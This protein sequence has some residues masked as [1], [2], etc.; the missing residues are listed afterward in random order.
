MGGTPR[1]YR[2]KGSFGAFSA[3]HLSSEK[4]GIGDHHVEPHQVVPLDERRAVQGVAPF[5]ARG[6]LLVQEH[7]HPR[8]GPGRAVDLLPVEGVV[9]RTDFVGGADQQRAGPTG[10][11]AYRV[12][13]LGCGEPGEQS[14]NGGRRIEF[15][16]LLAGVRREAR[17]E[18]EITL[19]DD[20]FGNLRRTKVE[21]RVCEI[22]EEVDEAAVAVLHPSEVGF[23]VEVDVAENAFELRT[24]RVLDL[25]Q[26]DVD[27]LAN[28]RF[29]T[30]FVQI[31][32][33]RTVGQD[34]A[35]AF[36]P[37]TDP[38]LV[39]PVTLPKTLHAVVPQV[40]DV[41]EEQHHEDVVLVLTGI[42][43]AP[44]GVAGGPGGLVD[45]L[46]GGRAGLALF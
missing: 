9:V 29:S 34:E 45:L 8:E 24:V 46:L 42:D 32:E 11:V 5:D 4:G 10:R 37:A 40:R 16:G 22:L 43:D 35:L 39:I 3:P 15:P 23:R 28:I 33:T 36:Q 27:Q 2:A 26:G 41:L 14:G 13:R 31:V 1:Q 30:P 12:A 20:I 7:V 19:A 17:D 38:A 18:V 25:L 44:E 21:G 6:V